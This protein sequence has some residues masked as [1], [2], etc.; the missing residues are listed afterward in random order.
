MRKVLDSKCIFPLPNI[1][2]SVFYTIKD[3]LLRYYCAE[4]ENVS[5]CLWYYILLIYI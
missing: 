4:I 3:L 2:F 5:F 1:E